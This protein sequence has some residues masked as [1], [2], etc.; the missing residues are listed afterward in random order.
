MTAYIRQ[1][2]FS[3]WT[4]ALATT[5]IVQ[6]RVEKNTLINRKLSR[7]SLELVAPYWVHTVLQSLL[8]LITAGDS[9]AYVGN[10]IEQKKRY[11]YS[12]SS[13]RLQHKTIT[14]KLDYRTCFV[15][16]NDKF[17]EQDYT[18]P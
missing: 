14:R 13:V 7:I 18:C 3:N 4:V 5:L 16:L 8:E 17:A 15:R 10:C 1:S 2:I 9:Q 11:A 12:Q 6:F